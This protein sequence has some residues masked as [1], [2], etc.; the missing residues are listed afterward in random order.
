[1]IVVTGAAGFIGS[2]LVWGLNRQE[3]S[4][5]LVVD[6]PGSS[7]K[8]GNLVNLQFSDIIDTDAFITKLEQGAFGNSIESIIHMGANT[9]T[10]ETDA[11]FL[12]S[13]NYE[14]TKR[15]AQWCIVNGRRFVY[16]SSAATYGDRV[17]DFSDDHS[18][19]PKLRPLNMYAYSKHL[20]DLW[21]WRHNYLDRIAGL[22]YFNVF[23][24]NEYHKGEMRSV[25]HQAFEQVRSTGKVK[26]FKSHR[27]EYKHGWQMRDFIYIKDVVE[28]TL[29][30]FSHPAINGIIN[31]GTGRARSFQD[32]VLAIFNSMS[33]KPDIEYIDMPESIRPRY[34]YFTQADVSRLRDLGYAKPTCSLEEAVADYVKSYLLKENSHLG[35][36]ED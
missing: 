18:I 14:Y 34:Q 12:I 24:P 26:L 21:A 29:F 20:F 27:P 35:N 13:N 25:V 22:K 16:A 4:D 11:D 31:V 10:T 30:V 19:L 6:S 23:G 15:L 33:L 36:G 32:L 3:T 17:E 5:I 8:W 28:M 7:N 1:M 2:A 9:D